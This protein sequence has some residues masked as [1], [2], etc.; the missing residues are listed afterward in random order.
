MQNM[1]PTQ[2]SYYIERYRSGQIDSQEWAALQEMLR[3]AGQQEAL[4]ALMD[5]QLAAMDAEGA[6]YP[7]MLERLKASMAGEIRKMEELKAPVTAEIR[8]MEELENRSSRRIWWAAAAVLLIAGAGTYG[9]LQ[10]SSMPPEQT[11]AADIAPGGKKATLT[12]ADGTVITLDSAGNR[13]LTQNGTTIHQHAGRLE[14]DAAHNKASTTYNT[15]KTPRG[16]QFQVKLPDGTEAWLNAASSITY[17]VAFTGNERTVSITGEVYFEVA[18]DARKPFKV[19]AGKQ[20]T[21]EV[22]GTSFNVNAYTNEKSLNTTLLD[23]AVKVNGILL[24][25]GQQAQ[26]NGSVKVINRVN[27]S[28]IMAWKR[29][30]FNFENLSLKEAMQQLERWY[31]IEVVYENGVPDIPFDGEI[32]RDVSLG[33]LLKMLE[34]VNLKFRMETGR[35]L[36]VTK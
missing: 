12:L 20:A 31:D 35:K 29:G 4:K 23:G 16:G 9:W 17:P 36:I 21:I 18:Q 34:G 22:L 19:N 30:L 33:G 25:P 2:L 8:K 5:E 1:E 14:Y 10:R 15:L 3:D 11:I 27:T 6:A 24:K 28:Q 26:L 7:G 32:S 13:T